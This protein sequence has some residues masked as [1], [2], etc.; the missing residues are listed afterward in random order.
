MDNVL[1][2]LDEQ[3][4]TYLRYLGYEKFIINKK[5]KVDEDKRKVNITQEVRVL[6]PPSTMY[7]TTTVNKPTE[8]FLKGAFFNSQENENYF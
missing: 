8:E 1:S 4:G 3:L 7:F 6:N 5:I 2:G